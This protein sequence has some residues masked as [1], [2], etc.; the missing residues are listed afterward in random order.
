MQY[1]NASCFQLHEQAVKDEI[2]AKKKAERR[3]RHLQDDLRYA[4]KKLPDP[5]DVSTSYEDAVSAME[6]LP[7]Y[8]ALDDE[9]RRAAFAKFIKRQKVTPPSSHKTQEV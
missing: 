7:E 8:K 3:Q 4:L 1:S 6:G 2:E 9:G 5:I